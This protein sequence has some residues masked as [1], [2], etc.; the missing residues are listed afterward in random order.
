MEGYHISQSASLLTDKG[1]ERERE[2]EEEHKIITTQKTKNDII[3]Y[4]YSNPNSYHMLC[5]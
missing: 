1:H 2:E 3:L 4:I 5:M